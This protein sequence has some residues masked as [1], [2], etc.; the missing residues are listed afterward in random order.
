MWFPEKDTLIFLRASEY[1]EQYVNQCF[2]PLT[3]LFPPVINHL[4]S[5]TER[6]Y[7]AT[8]LE[9]RLDYSAV[10]TENLT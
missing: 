3:S 6:G 8:L 5:S 4:S 2:K 10:I 1:G 9:E 7:Y